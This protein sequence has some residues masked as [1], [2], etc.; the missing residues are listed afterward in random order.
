MSCNAPPHPKKKNW[1]CLI[2]ILKVIST[3]Y[4]DL[5]WTWSCGLFQS[6]KGD[7]G[8][9]AM[10]EGTIEDLAEES[11]SKYYSVRKTYLFKGIIILQ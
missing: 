4:I 3:E 9:Q 8:G 5:C 7:K 11:F 10:A 2:H 1:F 6:S